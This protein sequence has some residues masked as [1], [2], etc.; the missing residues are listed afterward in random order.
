[1]ENM[2][3]LEMIACLECDLEAALAKIIL[4]E[5]TINGDESPLHD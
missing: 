5:A 2:T 4:L 3:E 1:M